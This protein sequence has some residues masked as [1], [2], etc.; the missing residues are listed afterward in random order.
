MS[1]LLLHLLVLPAAANNGPSGQTALAEIFLLPVMVLFTLL[2]GARPI[3]AL[4]QPGRRAWAWGLGAVLLIFLSGAQGGLAVLVATLFGLASVH[5]SG[6]MG[7]W[8]LRKWRAAPQDPILPVGGGPARLAVASGLNLLVTAWLVGLAWT[9][10]SWWP[11]EGQALR[12]AKDVAAYQ[13]AVGQAE[14]ARTGQ[15]RFQAP[16]S[17]EPRAIRF[18]KASFQVYGH[19]HTLDFSIVG[20]AAF[21]VELVPDGLPPWPYRWLTSLPAY[22]ADESGVVRALRV[23]ENGA[24]CPPDGPEV[25]RVGEADVARWTAQL[26]E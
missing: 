3:L 21:V 19:Q 4:L 23:R 5:R 20:D 13:L 22:R 25:D 16:E 9:F 26:E 15:V 1:P 11:W 8:A 12:V 6:Q 2:G 14:Q 18:Q 17:L 10:A 7:A 24:R